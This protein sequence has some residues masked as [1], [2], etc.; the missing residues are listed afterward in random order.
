MSEEKKSINNR[1][2]LIIIII[3]CVIAVVLIAVLVIR[4]VVKNTS[5]GGIVNNVKTQTMGGLDVLCEP[6]AMT[7]M[8]GR[9]FLVTDVYGKQIWL[10]NSFDGMVYAGTDSVEDLYGEPLGG[11]ND[12]E[13]GSSLFKEPWSITPFLDGYAVSDTG[14]D[15]VRLLSS[16][17]TQTVNGYSDIL[18]IGDL[19]VKFDT[20]TGLC[21]DEEGCLYIAETGK[22]AIRKVSTE[23]EVTTVCDGLDRPMGICYFDGWIYVAETGANRIVRVKDG[24]IDVIAGS[25][26]ET[27]EGGLGD[28]SVKKAT[29]RSPQGVAVAPDGTVFVADTISSTVR[30]IRNNKVTTI[31]QREGEQLDIEMYPVSPRGL[32]I[33]G[34][35]L[36]I[37]D[38]FARRVY[39]LQ[40][41]DLY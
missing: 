5:Y 25:G 29:F 38:P 10:I 26:E 18:E 12:A 16:E 40:I 24:K 36:Y 23:G 30:M 17:T 27:P 9:G 13:L 33:E 34:N 37:C 19:G 2:R 3:A 20:P 6:S 31:L 8:D 35:S 32:F 22:G 39:L 11:Y 4:S 28:G 41:S 14:N 15:A 7:I 21:T 1:T